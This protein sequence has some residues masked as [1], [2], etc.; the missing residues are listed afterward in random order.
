MTHGEVQEPFTPRGNSHARAT[1]ATD[2]TYVPKGTRE[3]L[4]ARL[5]LTQLVVA[6]IWA[7]P[8]SR[9]PNEK[10]DTEFH[11]FTKLYMVKPGT[12]PLS[13]QPRH[14]PHIRP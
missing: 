2:A 3:S 1:D 13:A 4:W 11:M 12:T 6:D 9:S 10:L 7:A 5:V 8:A 14:S